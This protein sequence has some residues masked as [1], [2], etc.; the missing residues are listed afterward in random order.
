LACVAMMQARRERET[1]EG[2]PLTFGRPPAPLEN[3]GQY[4]WRG[5]GGF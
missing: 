5:T 1:E 2:E 4:Y 3:R